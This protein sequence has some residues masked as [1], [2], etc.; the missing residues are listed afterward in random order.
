[1]KRFI[2]LYY[3]IFL[4]FS[5]SIIP[6]NKNIIH[7]L[8]CG[9]SDSIIIESKG[10][11]GLIDSSNPYKYIENEVEKVDI[12]SSKGEVNQWSENP[13][14]SVQ[15]VL[16]YLNYL[17][18]DKLKFIISTHSHSDHIG[19]IPAIA[20]KY[21]N[22][23]TKYYYK[24]YR[25]TIEDITNIDWA[26]KKYFIAAF[27]SM[28]KKNSEMIDVTNKN[29]SFNFNDLNL[30]LMNTEIDSD[31]L[32]LGENQHSIVTLIKFNKTKI[33]LTGDMISKH[34]KKLKDYIGKIDI[35]K[36]SHHGYSENS[37]EFIS[38][39]KPNYIIIFNNKIPS[40][41]NP[42]ISFSKQFFNSKI[43]LTQNVKETTESISDSAIKLFLNNDNNEFYFINTGN[44][45]NIYET[46]WFYW[47]DKWT[48]LN[49]G[50]LVQN[51][52]KLKWSKGENWFYFNDYGIMLTGWQKLKWSKGENWFYF[53]D[54][55]VMV[56]NKCMI[57]DNKNYCFDENG[58]LIK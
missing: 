20:Y 57:I 54:N 48:Y 14:E 6:N 13:N 12:D 39:I 32:N 29:I 8:H 24:E 34:D 9:S 43:Y 36:L 44:E 47:I 4:K 38:T 33:L 19:G 26:N 17:N 16:N 35:L 2:F 55:G 51:W 42:I 58:C 28:K 23:E 50:T 7:F 22:N 11:Y 3:I 49:N 1:M 40:Y 18:V 37:Y 45:I 41:S 30:E 46:G 10:E 27:N 21:V 31:E 53:E 56:Q 15:S 25:K 52:Q 5:N